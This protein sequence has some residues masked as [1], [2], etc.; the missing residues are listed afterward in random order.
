MVVL[1]SQDNSSVSVREH[2]FPVLLIIVVVLVGGE[3]LVTGLQQRRREEQA[4]PAY[5]AG[6][7]ADSAW[8]GPDKYEIPRTSDSGRLIWYGHELIAHTSHYL[9][10]RGTVRQI[11]NGMNCQNCHLDGGTVPYGNN[12]GKVY[13]TY[14][15]FRARNNGIQTIYDRINDCLQRSLNGQPLDSSSREMQA[16]YAYI[17]WLAHGM[18]HGEVQRGTSLMQLAYLDRAADPVAGRKVYMQYCQRC[19]GAEG[20]G[21]PA[22]GADE[23]TYPPLWGQHSYNDG[24]GMYRLRSFAGFVKNNMPFGT[25]YHSPALSDAEAWDVAA[26]INS[27]PRPHFDQSRDWQELS[28]KPVDAPYG[29]YADTFSEAQHKYGPWKPVVKARGK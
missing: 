11:S 8:R 16:I 26:Y 24:A 14:P 18:Q 13:T 27:Q 9:G 2:W 21:Q 28:K 1:T 29:P 7:P 4:F 12:Y 17:R 6:S 25:D 20:Q 15:Q 19:H 5:T 23:Y 3:E 10:P 22:P